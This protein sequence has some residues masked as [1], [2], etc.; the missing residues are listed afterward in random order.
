MRVMRFL[1]TRA[2]GYDLVPAPEAPAE[3][4]LVGGLV[5]AF[6]LSDEPLGRQRGRLPDEA[7]SAAS[8]SSSESVG[9]AVKAL[10]PWLAMGGG[11]FP[12]TNGSI[13]VADVTKVR[14]HYWTLRG[15]IGTAEQQPI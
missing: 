3:W 5:A 8:S 4:Q 10:P 15:Y 13:S 9:N 1:R 2:G 7:P 11:I 14:P 6:G 12:V